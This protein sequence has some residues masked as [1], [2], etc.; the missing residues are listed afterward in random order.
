MT[1]KAKK[2]WI[3]VATVIVMAIVTVLSVWLMTYI[4]DDD[5]KVLLQ[6]FISSSGAWGLLAFVGIQALQVLV[7]IIPGE[8]IEVLGG[9]LF[10]TWGGYF[11]CLVGMMLGTV[12]IFYTMRA[13]GRGKR[14][15]LLANPKFAQYK[16]LNESTRLNSLVFALFFIPGTPKDILT[17]FVPFTR[18]KAHTFFIIVAVARFPSMIS[19]TYAGAMMMEGNWQM[20]LLTFGVIAVIGIVGILV[21]NKLMAK[22]NSATADAETHPNI[23]HDDSD[24]NN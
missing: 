13:L 19:S 10:G 22:H 2:I 1:H 9:V 24:T 5:K 11:S 7:A 4:L 23:Q 20:T 8:P 21:N 18:M 16:F 3:I 12:A 6:Q 15:K 17:Y 14:D